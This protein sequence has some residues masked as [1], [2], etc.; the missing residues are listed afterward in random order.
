[1]REMD[2]KVEQQKALAENMTRHNAQKNQL[3]PCNRY[4]FETLGATKTPKMTF[5]NFLEKIFCYSLVLFFTPFLTT[6]RAIQATVF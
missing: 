1:M 2:V 4:K 3:F 5:Q 6:F